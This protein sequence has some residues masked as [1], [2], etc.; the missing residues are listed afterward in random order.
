MD[1]DLPAV[2]DLE[3]KIQDR[4]SALQQ[5]AALSSAGRCS[6]P[7]VPDSPYSDERVLLSH[8]RL[9]LDQEVSA[10]ELQLLQ[11]ESEVVPNPDTLP[12]HAAF[13]AHYESLYSTVSHPP[14]NEIDLFLAEVPLPR[15]TGEQCS[16]LDSPPL[17]SEVQEAN[18]SLAND[19][20][21][22]PDGLPA[23]FYKAYSVQL[24]PKLLTL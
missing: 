18:R 9:Q 2:P 11:H 16:E 8:G 6:S 20:A 23:E 19:K 4:R 10:E 14:P 12:I 17:L 22:G 21:P 5:A 13:H 1:R 15:I 24:A 7:I 3:Q